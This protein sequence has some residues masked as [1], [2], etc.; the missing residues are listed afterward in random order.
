MTSYTWAYRIFLKEKPA[1]SSA[2]DFITQDIQRLSHH[3]GAK[4]GDCDSRSFE[5]QLSMDVVIMYNPRA[6]AK[7]SFPDGS[8]IIIADCG[9]WLAYHGKIDGDLHSVNYRLRK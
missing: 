4:D 2:T 3:R 9:W 8:E 6:I 5:Q 7:V 1:P